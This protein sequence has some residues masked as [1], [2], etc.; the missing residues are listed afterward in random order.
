MTTTA[1]TSTDLPVAGF[2][3]NDPRLVPRHTISAAPLF[4]ATILFV[5]VP[6]ASGNASFHAR[7]FAVASLIVR[8]RPV[9]ISSL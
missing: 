7:A 1:R 2:P 8:R 5:I 4:P 6:R 3:I 9:P